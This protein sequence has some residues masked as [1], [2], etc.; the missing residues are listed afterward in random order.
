MKSQ[1]KTTYKDR[2]KRIVNLNEF[3][4]ICP[5]EYVFDYTLD[6]PYERQYIL[7]MM[8]KQPHSDFKIPS[9]LNW[10]SD[11][12]EKCHKNQIDNNI[13]QSY[14]YITVRHGLHDAVTDDE[15]HT[16]GY[17]EVISHI[18]EQNY[19][20]T[21]NDCTEYIEMPI[22]FPKD[23]DSLKHNVVNYINNEV[24]KRKPKIKTAEPNKV[25]VFDPYVIHRRP[26]EAFGKKRT[27]VRIT[28]VPIEIYDDACEPNQFI[29]TKRYNRTADD[30]RKILKEYRKDIK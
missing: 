29:Y 20:V 2:V 28:F 9:E 30:T 18:P 26:P 6:C 27:F 25:Y 22:L 1:N 8:I 13:R 21:S 14:C 11:L 16:D 23:F 19:I 10:V 17:S 12:V 7:R 15:W 3:E 5:P 24:D 4:N